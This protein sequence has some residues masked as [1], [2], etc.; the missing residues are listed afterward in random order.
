MTNKRAIPFLTSGKDGKF[1]VNSEA[2]AILNAIKAPLAVVAVAGLWRTGKVGF[3]MAVITNP[4]LT[5]H[6]SFPLVSPFF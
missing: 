5:R 6:P 1:E 3:R 2:L 4:S